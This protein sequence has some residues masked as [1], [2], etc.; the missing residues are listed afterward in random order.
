MTILL[1]WLAGLLVLLA[2][3]TCAQADE[4]ILAFHSDITVAADG[5]M[6][7]AETIRVRAEGDRIRHG[8]YRDFPTDYRDRYNNRV[9]VDFEPQSLTRDGVSEPWHSEGQANGV[10]VYFGAKDTVLAPNDYTYVL[11][12]RTTR[13]LGFFPDHD[14]LYWN[15][16]GNGWDFAID[17]ASAAVRL[18]GAI[19]QDQLHVEAYTGAQGA[20]G[21]DYRATVD[22]PSHARFAATRAL[23]P[24]EGL[25]LVVT[26]PK[27]VAAAPTAGEQA[28]SFLRDNAA[29]LIGLIGLALAWLYFLWQWNRVGRDPKPGVI[30]P[31]Y[32]APD[33]FSPGALRHIERMGYDE[34]CFAADLV[35]LGVRGALR[36]SQ[37]DSTF[38]LQR[39]GNVRELPPPPE[40]ALLESLLGTRDRLELKQSEHATIGA[41]LSAHKQ[42]LKS[43]NTGRYFRTNG[44]LVIPGAML[45]LAA[46]LL[47]L[48]AHGSAPTLA[49]AGFLLVWLGG[50]SIG[51][52]VLLVSVIGAW[53]KSSGLGSR[54][55]ALFLTLFAVPFVLG[56]LFGIGALVM[57]TGMGFGLVVAAL[58]ATNI[59]FYQWLK[60][61]TLEGRKVLDRIAGLRLYIGIA[62]RDDLA[63]QSAPPMTPDEFQKFLPYALA[64]GIE[65]TWADRFAAA[66]GPAAAAAAVSTMAWYQGSSGGLSNLSGFT[67]GLGASLSGAISSSSTAPGSSS[68]SGG[69]GSSGGGGGGGGGGGW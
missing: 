68:G 31:Q 8:I 42:L 69:G 50:W 39:R 57:I 15:A 33:G 59:A 53:R 55:A 32:E 30:M 25:T 7:V 9:H 24:R 63:R 67:S 26:F 61:P 40:A 20:K 48:F 3:M 14:E 54:A 4:R 5:S 43:E 52:G 60:A 46:L 56:E 34:R 65:K 37:D 21:S 22:A 12:Y 1:R 27:G 28:R 51:V 38:S 62:E 23:E 49:G 29:V 47:G 17:N 10:R 35:D 66:V 44:S 16:T 18:P 11:S 2:L 13:Q 64:L 41:A 45:G 6:Q 36:I 19:A 58:V